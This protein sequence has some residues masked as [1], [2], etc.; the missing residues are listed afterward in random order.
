MQTI[1]VPVRLRLK[2]TCLLAVLLATL[3]CAVKLTPYY[4]PVLDQNVTA[5]QTSTETYLTKLENL[6]SPACTYQNNVDFYQQASVQLAIMRTRV[7]ASPHPTQLLEIFDS[8]DKTYQDLKKLQ[9]DAGDKCLNTTVI[10]ISRQAFEREF[11]S[12]LAYELAL[13]ANQPPATPH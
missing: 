5:F 1:P 12:L 10:E 7:T 6:Q 9:Q 2:Q 4:D 3:G 13:K 11:E 8:L